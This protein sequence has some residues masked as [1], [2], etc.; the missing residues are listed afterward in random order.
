M[1]LVAA[2]VVPAAPALIP[3]LGG[4]ADPLAEVREMARGA[5]ADAVAEGGAD[6]YVVVVSGVEASLQGGRTVRRWAIGAPSGAGR[7]L[8]AGAPERALPAGLE[9]GRM[10]L[11][12]GREAELLGVA[13]D[14]GAQECLTA[15]QHQI[16]SAGTV[17]IVVADGSATR[18]EKAPGHLDPRAEGFDAGLARALAEVDG[19]ALA[20][21]DPELAD[22]LWC[23]GRAALQVLAGA[24]EAGADAGSGAGVGADPRSGSDPGPGD[25][26]RLRG[27]VLLD[28]AP[29]G[30]GYLVATWR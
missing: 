28:E 11:P 16:G 20:E 27:E 2:A 21:L 26:S 12:E 23:R 18:T 30:V 6:P 24:L 10:L 4:A 29:F 14:A 3:G 15:G 17:L 22:A 7:F 1:S 8:G 13:R 5:V 9:I 25:R 19:R